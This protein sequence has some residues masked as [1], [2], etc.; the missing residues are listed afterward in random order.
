MSKKLVY[1]SLAVLV[2]AIGLSGSLVYSSQSEYATEEYLESGEGPYDVNASMVSEE[3]ALQAVLSANINPSEILYFD[4]VPF[5]VSGNGDS[6]LAWVA[7]VKKGDELLGT[8]VD[9]FTGK[10]LAN[11]A[12]LHKGLKSHLVSL[13]IMDGPGIDGIG[14][15]ESYP[16]GYDLPTNFGNH[17]LNCGYGPGCSQYHNGDNYY[18]VDFGMSYGECIPAPGSGY[19][20]FAGDRGDGYG[21]QVIIKAGSTG[22]PGK[23]YVY[24]VAHL[25]AVYVIPGW[26]VD[27]GRTLG[28]A[29]CTGWCTGTHLHFSIHRGYYSGGRIYGASVPL[30]RWPGPNDRVDYFDRNQYWQFSFNVCRQSF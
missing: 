4:T 20:M 18:A 19:V 3:Q 15:Y 5:N 11:N 29:G 8:F 6:E 9:I 25:S 23:D 7:V 28:A 13:G 22:I 26:W 24:R 30:D 2:M 21:K 14:Q 10:V 12:L 27:K 1:F 16:W 17:S